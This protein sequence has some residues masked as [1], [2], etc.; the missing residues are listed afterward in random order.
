MP[1][2]PGYSG[3]QRERALEHSISLFDVAS[4]LIER[5]KL[6]VICLLVVLVPSLII[7]LLMPNQYRS[8]A[9]ILPSKQADNLQDLKAIASMFGPQIPIGGTPEL[10]PVVLRS[11]LI[12]GVILEHKYAFKM[13]NVDTSVTLADYFGETNRDK[14]QVR[15]KNITTISTDKKTGTISIG[16]ETEH[17]ELSQAIV[18]T[19]LAEL[20]QYNLY[21]RT[22]KAQ[23]ME[24]YLARESAAREEIL[25][26]AQD[27]LRIFQEKHRNWNQ[28]SNPMILR[29]LA[30]LRRGVTILEQN[31]IYLSREHEAAKLEVEL[32][33]PILTILDLPFL[34]E[35]KSGPYRLTI[36]TA[37]GFLAL[38]VTLM[39]VAVLNGIQG[40]ARES[41]RSSYGRL[42]KNIHTAFPTASRLILKVRHSKIT[43]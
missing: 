5:R 26:A 33:T 36:L 1:V 32:D 8:T 34:P 30:R 19:Y 35:M 4:L 16:V 28:T 3:S 6:I 2:N 17:P 11:R 27:S 40:R 39:L 43:S 10:F 15:L 18:Q 23:M 41:E 21:S 22:T 12:T 31:F 7:L 13:N 9:T 38:A 24:Q 37:I 29:E 42:R 20:E 25:L 14:L